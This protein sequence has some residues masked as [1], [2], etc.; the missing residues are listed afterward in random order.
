MNDELSPE[1]YATW[2]NYLQSSPVSSPFSM[3]Y[4]SSLISLSL[5]VSSWFIS[6]YI[7]V[8]MCR[9]LR[10]TE[11]DDERDYQ[12]YLMKQQPYEFKYPIHEKQYQEYIEQI[13]ENED[14][15]ENE[16]QQMNTYVMEC[17]PEGTVILNY[18]EEHE[19][20]RYW[21]NKTIPYKY[22]EA[23]ARKF[24]NMTGRYE[25]YKSKPIFYSLYEEIQNEQETET[26]K[27]NESDTNNT[28]EDKVENEENEDK[29]ENE[30]KQEEE[31]DV[32]LRSNKS[33][34]E[35]D[36]KEKENKKEHTKLNAYRKIGLLE[37][38]DI[39]QQEQYRK[40]KNVISFKEFKMLFTHSS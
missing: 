11:E 7:Y 6:K 39:L 20:F 13:K 16:K 38:F 31:F 15:E 2:K 21:S 36:E 10:D 34:K 24:V 23:V 3:L 32:F 29:V 8:P 30:D 22:L 25:W 17:T 14:S 19:H 4:I 37:D 18:D 28:K 27:E 9:S 40:K 1:V 35:Q 12:L 26:K 33:T 5:T